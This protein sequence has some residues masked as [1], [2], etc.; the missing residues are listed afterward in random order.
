VTLHDLAAAYAVDALDTDEL[1]AF[2]AHLDGCSACR[3]EVASLRETAAV[4][5]A[6]GAL[7]GIA[8]TG[9]APAALRARVVAA[10]PRT[11]QVS[12]PRSPSP[13]AAPTR[14]SRR[15]LAWLGAAAAAVLVA[16]L[17]IGVGGFL[18]GSP[19]AELAAH[20]QAMRI[21]SAEDAHTM[22][23]PLGHSSFV[24]SESYGGAVLMGDAT[25]MPTPGTEYQ[26]WMA[27]ASGSPEAGPTFM[28]EHDG[29][30]MV[31]MNGDMDGVTEIYVTMEPPGGSSTPTGPMVAEANVHL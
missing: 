18:S 5:G 6:S 4:V 21:I 30:Y 19:D 26:V 25:P 31:L 9:R 8:E 2:T 29:T 28:P 16:A 23:V 1:A 7:S 20:E 11:P 14:P 10:A 17:G 12:A 3:E 13:A 24:M 27:H 22:S 15:P